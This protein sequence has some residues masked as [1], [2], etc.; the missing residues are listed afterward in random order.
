[1]ANLKAQADMAELIRW[2]FALLF[3]SGKHRAASTTPTPVRRP[4]SAPVTP[5]QP[6]DGESLPLVRPYV[7]AAEERR[8]AAQ[9]RQRRRALVL[10]TMGIDFPGVAR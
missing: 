4:V 8:E 10:A 7:L 5:W 3:P 6:L 2:L 1:M 9:Q